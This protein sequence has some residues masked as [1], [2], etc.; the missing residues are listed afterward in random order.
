MKTF[1]INLDSAKERLRATAQELERLGL[2]FERVPGVDGRRLP[3]E[4]VRREVCA[5]R[6]VLCNARRIQLPEVGCALANRAV[7]ERVAESAE[8]FT[9]VLED[10][11]VAE[12]AERCRDALQYVEAHGDPEKAQVWLLV[13]CPVA[14]SVEQKGAGEYPVVEGASCASAYVLTRP[15]ARRLAKA[16]TPIVALCDSWARWQACG[17]A[18]KWLV[19][20]VFRARESVSQIGWEAPRRARWGWYRGLWR[21]RHAFGVWVDRWLLRHEQGKEP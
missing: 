3:R 7:W 21:V 15:A 1:V 19:P 6:F 5:W 11:V 10:D 17:V 12:S 2:D 18:V 16:N 20:F 8:P 13:G 9:L 14:K 4:V